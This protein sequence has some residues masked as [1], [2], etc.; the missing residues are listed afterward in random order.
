MCHFLSGTFQICTLSDYIY[1]YIVLFITGNIA[2]GKH[3]GADQ[4]STLDMY[5]KAGNGVDGDLTGD[6]SCA[7][8]N[9]PGLPS[10]PSS[11]WRLDLGSQHSIHNVTIY[12]RISD[13]CV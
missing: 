12:D 4:S 10:Y 8:T 6:K 9:G 7:A 3:G 2:H 1:A 13:C 5:S 11:W